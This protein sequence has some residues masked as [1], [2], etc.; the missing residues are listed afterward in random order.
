MAYK[1]LHKACVEE[2]VV[3]WLPRNY[4]PH[5]NWTRDWNEAYL[6]EHDDLEYWLERQASP[7]A[8]PPVQPSES[9]RPA[10]ENDI[11]TEIRAVY[12]SGDQPNI[13]RLPK[14]VRPNLNARGLDASDNHIQTIG[15][16]SE[17]IARR[18]PPGRTR[19][20]DRM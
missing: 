20:S 19:R 3:R 6:I 13:N 17:F 12:S 2:E 4:G 18:R 8:A 9:F 7:P 16:E 5:T 14:V 11:R 1:L 10:S 15:N